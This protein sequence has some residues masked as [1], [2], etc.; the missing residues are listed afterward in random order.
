MLHVAEG[1]ASEGQD[2]GP[3]LGVRDHLNP[4][5]VGKSG[6]AIVAK[7]AKDEVLA[8]L[9]EDEDSGQHRGGSQE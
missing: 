2:R 4:E 6:P 3:D 7:G 9:V 1:G 5:D 8:L